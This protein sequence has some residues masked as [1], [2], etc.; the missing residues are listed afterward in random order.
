MPKTHKNRSKKAPKFDIFDYLCYNKLWSHLKRSVDFIL[1]S[2]LKNCTKDKK[3]LTVIIA[4]AIIILVSIV[5]IKSNYKIAYKVTIDGEFVGYIEDQ[6]KFAYKVANEVLNKEDENIELVTLESIP[7]YSL[8]I[9]N[10]NETINEQTILNIL[11]LKSDV[12]YKMYAVTLNGEDKAYVNTLDEAKEKV[13]ELTENYGDELEESEFGVRE[14]YTD[15]KFEYKDMKYATIT[16]FTDNIETEIKKQKEEAAIRNGKVLN[17]VIFY[18]TPVSGT[19]TSRYGVN[20]SVRD[21]THKGIDIAARNGTTIVAPADGVV[22]SASYCGGYGNLIVISHGDGVETYYGHCSKMYVSAGQSV[23]AGEAIGAV[24]STG[25][26]TGNH[27]H[28]EVRLNGN[29]VNPQNYVY[30]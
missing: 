3:K 23:T 28:F 14:V 10:K 9:V 25:H 29:Q 12:T 4:V 16:K 26:S 30:K 24:G 6:D 21:H 7:E 19:I 8:A 18:N 20:E 15:N 11:K 13:A 5:L 2:K 1:N 17:S 22:K 27:L